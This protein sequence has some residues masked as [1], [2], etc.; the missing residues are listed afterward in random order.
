MMKKYAAAL[1]AVLMMTL[2]ACGTI[3]PPQAVETTATTTAT[4][5]VTTVPTVTTVP[6]DDSFELETTVPG[7]TEKEKKQLEAETFIAEFFDSDITFEDTSAAVKETLKKCSF[8]NTAKAANGVQKI[9]L[10]GD[11]GA[12]MIEMMC[13]D[14]SSAKLDNDL[15]YI[16]GTFGD[17]RYEQTVSAM[18]GVS[19]DE[20][21]S[22]YR[23]TNTVV[24]KGR[25]Q[26]YGSLQKTDGEANQFGYA[27]TYAVLAENKLTVVSGYFLS[28][29]MMERQTFTGLLKL[30]KEKIAF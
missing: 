5:A 13:I 3:T 28:T 2:T 22:N 12:G 6:V 11:S 30:F 4:S 29:D 21:T 17:Y 9:T 25:Y 24:S 10:K 23:L 1:A 27:E 19:A 15:G 26:Q 7:M 20:F 18:K 8:E 16:L 14:L